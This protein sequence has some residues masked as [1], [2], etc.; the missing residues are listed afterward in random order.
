MERDGSIRGTADAGNVD[1]IKELSHTEFNRVSIDYNF[2]FII[3]RRFVVKQIVVRNQHVRMF[4]NR[5]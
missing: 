1:S 5:D 3:S 2:V 4:W